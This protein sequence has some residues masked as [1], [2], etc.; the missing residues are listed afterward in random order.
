MEDMRQSRLHKLPSGNALDGFREGRREAM[1]LVFY[2]IKITDRNTREKKQSGSTS[3]WSLDWGE[4]GWGVLD[5]WLQEARAGHG[6][7]RVGAGV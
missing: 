5:P 7:G 4:G 2:Q 3:L 1:Q 6:T